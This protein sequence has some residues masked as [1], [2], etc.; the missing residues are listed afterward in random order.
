M[1]S[2]DLVS[3]RGIAW[4]SQLALMFVCSW[5]ALTVMEASDFVSFIFTAATKR[6]QQQIV[7][8][9]IPYMYNL[10]EIIKSYRGETS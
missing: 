5:V 1:L 3:C 4:R 8:G 7:S 6:P 2:I 9:I 10:K